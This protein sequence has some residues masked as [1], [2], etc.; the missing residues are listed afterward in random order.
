MESN[1]QA[2][3]A[4][5]AADGKVMPLVLKNCNYL[6]VFTSQWLHGDIAIDNGRI[7]GI[8][9]YHGE[10]E[11]DL[12]GKTCV[13]GMID[14]H[15]HLESAMITPREF[16]R[17]AV[18]HGTAAVVADPHEIANVLGIDGV[19]YMLQAS[20]N[21]PL[22]VFFMAPSCVPSSPFDE[23]GAIL[24]HEAIAPLLANPRVLGLAEM[25]NVPGVLAGDADV[26]LKIAETKRLH[27]RIDGHAPGLSG[28]ALQAYIAAGIQTDHECSALPEALE[29][30]ALGQWIM[31]REGSAARNLQALLPLFNRP[32]CNRCLLVTDDKH[33]GDLLQL[34]HIDHMVRKAISLGAD[35]AAAY[36]M[37]SWNAAQCFGLTGRG[38]IAP[39]YAADIVVMDNVESAAIHSVYHNGALVTPAQ[40]TGEETPMPAS[41]FNM[42]P[43]TPQT[44][45]LKEAKVIGLVPGELLTTDEGSIS[46]VDPQKDIVKLA[47]IERHHGSGHVGKAY[48]KGYGL[49]SG[50]IATSVAHDA[51][52]LILA[53]VSDEDMALAANRVADMQGGIAVVQNGKVLASLPLPIAGLM[54]PRPAEEVQE[55]LTR[56]ME[57]AYQLGVSKQI[58]PFMTL[59]FVSLP[60]IPTLRLTTYGVV[61]AAAQVLL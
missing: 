44:F 59:S 40:I 29:K 4:A 56:L 13:P 28:S 22:D 60:V 51:H 14:G 49:K 58:D 10:R 2:A 46:A 50:A 32:Y 3:K 45:A 17:V 61:D 12:T 8:G 52:N 25:M 54:S 23:S 34:G 5:C 7:V 16:A 47:V 31:I 18:A 48:V 9:A 39:G 42:A 1:Q 38:A 57:H 26:M 53:G 36:T 24:N 21:L 11:I 55:A 33:P 37:A 43:V 19:E 30:L 27:K 20:E 15:I 41:S 35:S 6:N